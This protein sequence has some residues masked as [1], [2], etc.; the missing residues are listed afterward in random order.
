MKCGLSGAWVADN[1]I[2]NKSAIKRSV[3]ARIGDDGPRRDLVFSRAN[4]TRG[5]CAKWAEKS[6]V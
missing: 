1:Q 5:E 6:N 2:E 3:D 4:R